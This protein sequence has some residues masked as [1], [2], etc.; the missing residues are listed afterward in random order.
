MYLQERDHVLRGLNRAIAAL[1]RFLDERLIPESGMD[2][3]YA[4]PN[5][6]DRG[7]V[8]AVG[9]GIRCREDLQTAADRIAFGRGGEAM[10]SVLTAMRH[11]PSIRSC[12]TLRCTSGVIRSMEALFFT[13]CSFDPARVP[14]GIEAV[15][16][17]VAFCCREGVPDAIWNRGREGI[18]PLVRIFAEDPMRVAD[19]IIKI[20]AR[21]QDRAIDT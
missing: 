2:I 13:T 10:R 14:P 17:G 9:E 3:V 1:N 16:W 7:D 21:I 15:E 18:E 4:M 5:A 12:A 11:D 19:N 8:A 6:R 20:S